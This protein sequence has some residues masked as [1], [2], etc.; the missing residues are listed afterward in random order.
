VGVWFEKE[1]E[2]TR[3]HYFAF[4]REVSGGQKPLI[5]SRLSTLLQILRYRRQ[6]LSIGIRNI[7]VSEHAVVMGLQHMSDCNVCYNFPGTESPLLISRYRFASLFSSAFDRFFF[8]SLARKARCIL[9]AADGQAISALKEKSYGY[10]ADRHVRSF[11]TRVDTS[12]F[13]PD[14]SRSARNEFALAL[15]ATLVVTS[16]RIH[17]AKGWH[18]LLEAFELFLKSVPNAMLVFVGDGPDRKRLE[19]SAAEKN[20][21]ARILVTGYLTSKSVA[22][23]LQAADLFVM[24]SLKEGWSTAL[25]EALACGLPSVTTRFSSADSIVKNGING[26]VVERDP[27]L[28]SDAMRRALNLHDVDVYARQEIERYA[29]RNMERDLNEV[30]PLEILHAENR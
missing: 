30:W 7:I 3:Y 12:I 18:F 22:G 9:A 27:K 8:W 21:G 26:Y 2:G 17:W 25:L 14:T 29:L 10:L 5:P 16:G 15:D 20:L 28:F 1:I 19:E 4:G 24:G 23:Y 11:P 13:L 6:I